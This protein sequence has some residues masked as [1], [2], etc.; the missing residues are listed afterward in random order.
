MSFVEIGYICLIRSDKEEDEIYVHDLLNNHGYKPTYLSNK[1]ITEKIP[2]C[3]NEF[4]KKI[5]YDDN[6]CQIKFFWELN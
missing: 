5:N 6:L 4:F 2:V 1:S 3:P